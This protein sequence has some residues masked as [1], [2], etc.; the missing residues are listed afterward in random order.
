MPRHHWQRSLHLPCRLRPVGSRPGPRGIQ[1]ALPLLLFLL[2]LLLLTLRTP[3]ASSV[4]PMP[5]SSAC[6]R[7]PKEATDSKRDGLSPRFAFVNDTTVHTPAIASR[8]LP[9][10]PPRLSSPP[11]VTAHS[12]SCKAPVVST[13]CH[14]FVGA[15]CP[16][17]PC[18]FGT[19]EPLRQCSVTGCRDCLPRMTLHCMPPPQRSSYLCRSIRR[20]ENWLSSNGASRE[21]AGS[22]NGRS[23]ALCVSSFTGSM[24]PAHTI[25]S[26]Y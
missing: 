20:R 12:C 14:D 9:F 7:T 26:P 21:W 4:P 5:P 16:P 3:A 1:E 25:S 10:S 15:C 13:S 2:L 19:G 8:A 11:S 6:A 23:S 18:R 22:A 24:A 17:E